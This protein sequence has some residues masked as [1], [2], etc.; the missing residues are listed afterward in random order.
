MYSIWKVKNS[1]NFYENYLK[2]L[3]DESSNIDPIAN[4]NRLLKEKIIQYLKEKYPNLYQ[5]GYDPTN[6]YNFEDN[7]HL[8][9]KSKKKSQDPDEEADKKLFA[10]IIEP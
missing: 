2:V 7:S 9:I 8:K 1:E 5:S 6:T 10:T 3:F 4:S